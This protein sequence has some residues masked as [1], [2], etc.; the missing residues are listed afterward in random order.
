M[1][2]LTTIVSVLAL[3]A[4]QVLAMPAVKFL[5]YT[6]ECASTYTVLSGDTCNAIISKFNNSFTLDQFYSWNPEVAKD[7]S[8]LWPGEQVCVAIQKEPSQPGCPAPTATGISASCNACYHVVE[9][10]N[11]WAITQ[12][13]HISLDDFRKWNPSI[14]AACSN[15]QL[16]YNY[17][18][19]VK[20]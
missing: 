15:L 16:G 18:V 9:G 11:C 5:R 12:S 2:A 14:D 13:K 19:G 4:N 20:A 7:C 8:N 10:D 17:C 1:Y 3:A 6:S